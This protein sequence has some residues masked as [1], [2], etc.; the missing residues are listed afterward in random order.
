REPAHLLGRHVTK[1]ALEHTRLR[2]HGAADRLGDAEIDELDLT[3]IGHEHVLRRH[4]SMDDAQRLARRILLAVSVIEPFADLAA[5][6]SRHVRRHRLLHPLEPLVNLE[7]VFPPHIFHRNKVALSNS[8][9]LEDL[10]HVRVAELASDL[11][12]IDEH[13]DEFTVLRHGWNNAL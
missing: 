7:E 10:A 12:F 1:L 8:T 4:V 5:D 9:E 3:V 2:S 6:E 11:G 13:L